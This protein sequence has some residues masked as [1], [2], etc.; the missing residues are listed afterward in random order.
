MW[1]FPSQHICAIVHITSTV[2]NNKIEA[3]LPWEFVEPER[4]TTEIEDVVIRR[5]LAFKFAGHTV[6][7]LLALLFHFQEARLSHDPEMLGNVI[8]RHLQALRDFV[9]P[10]LLFEKQTQNPKPGLLTQSF[11]GS[12]TIDSRHGAES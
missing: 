4:A 5:Y 3:V 8:L 11:Q 7:P 10:Q 12:N 9:Y 1:S 6:K 2:R